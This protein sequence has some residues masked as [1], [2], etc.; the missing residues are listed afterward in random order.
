MKKVRFSNNLEEIMYF[1]K[2]SFSIDSKP[3]SHSNISKFFK[4]NIQTI[5]FIVCFLLLFIN[6]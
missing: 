4:N 2:D 5:L 3:I 6:L 1:D